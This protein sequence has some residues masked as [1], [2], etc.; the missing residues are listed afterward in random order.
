[1]DDSTN[2]WERIGPFSRGF[3]SEPS[4]GRA[5]SGAN[6]RSGQPGFGC[7]IRSIRSTFCGFS[8]VRG[9]SCP[10]RGSVPIAAYPTRIG[11]AWR[12][13]PRVAF[14]KRANLC[15]GQWSLP[16]LPAK[17]VV[18]CGVPRVGEFSL[19]TTTATEPTGHWS[20]I[21]RSPVRLKEPTK[22][23]SSSY[24]WSAGCTTVTRVRPP[25]PRESGAC[26][27]SSPSARRKPAGAPSVLPRIIGP[28]I[29]RPF[30]R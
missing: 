3:P 21:V 24:P 6:R 10:L 14:F 23:R 27:E 29:S 1:M 28:M 15:A 12:E 5:K 8:A 16:T 30:C 18:M 9:S 7:R 26:P 17:T 25:D 13:G 4:K 19:P 11:V 2:F 22:A 20:A